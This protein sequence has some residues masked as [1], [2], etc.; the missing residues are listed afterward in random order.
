MNGERQRVAYPKD[1]AEGIAARPQMGDLAQKLH[2]VALFLERIAV[3]VGRPIDLDV[4]SL[5]FDRLAF[6]GRGHQLTRH[7]HAGAGGRPAERIVGNPVR[8]GHNLERLKT[9]AV[10]QLEKVDPLAAT[11]G[12]DPA[13]GLDCGADRLG[14]QVTYCP[15]CLNHPVSP[16]V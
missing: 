1:G 6:A 10:V 9:R 2:A 11:V 3:R 16:C 5:Q 13:S 8:V 4:V 12:S 14:Q 15:A 7:P